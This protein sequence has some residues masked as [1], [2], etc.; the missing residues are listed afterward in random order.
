MAGYHD[1]IRYSLS[2]G[3]TGRISLKPPKVIGAAVSRGTRDYQEDAHTV[4]AVHIPP[5]ELRHSL[6]RYFGLNWDPGHIGETLAG[7]VL[8]AGIYDGHGGN[9]VSRYLQQQLHALFEQVDPSE[10]P[11]L[12]SGLQDEATSND[13][14]AALS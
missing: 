12:V 5:A 10:V 9:T 11:E 4:T 14:K 8:F 6:I 13:S 1:F 7:Q 2:E 3:R